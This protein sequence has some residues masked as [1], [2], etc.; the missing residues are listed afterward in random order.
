[1]KNL[2]K[3]YVFTNSRKIRDFN[4][5]FE[6]GLIPKTINIAEF[7]KK[8]IYVLNRFEADSTY[9]LVLM[10]QA[11]SRVKAAS[12]KLKIPTEFFAFL[13]NNNYLFS[14]FKELAIQKRSINDIKFRDIYADYE[15]HLS[16]LEEVLAAYK[17]LLANENLYDDIVLPEIYSL[18][19]T[20]ICSFDEIIV[21]IDG[22][23]SEFELE[24]F[25]KISHLTKLKFIFS[26]SKF[27]KKIINKIV[28]IFGLNADELEL[29]AKFE[30]D[31]SNKKFDKLH[32]LSTQTIVQTRSF[33]LRSLQ[34]AYVMAKIGEFVRDG[35]EAQNIVV[36]LPDESFS[37]ILRLYDN[38]RILNYAMGQSFIHTKFFQIL[39]LI[40]R[41]ISED[42]QI[43]FD[44]K[45]ATSYDEFGFKFN[46]FGISEEL[47]LQFKNSFDLPCKF[48]K[49]EKLIE[50]IIA[51]QS[52]RRALKIINKVMFDMKNLARY[53][54]FNLRQICEI[55]LMRLRSESIDD[56]G[57]GKV[58]VIGILESRGMKFDGVIVVDFNDDLIPKR[59][60]NEMFLSSRVR[61]K[62]GLISHN[63]RENLQRF[64]YESLIYGSKKSA[65]CYVQ[66][67]EKI[68][69][70][71]LK[72]FTCIVDDKYSDTSL[73]RL[74]G[75]GSVGL[76]MHEN[77]LIA[78]HDFFAYPLSFSRLNTFLNSPK[79]YYYKYILGIKE[80]KAIAQKTNVDYGNALH[81]V[82]FDYYSKYR[83]FKL[84]RFELILRNSDF[85]LLDIEILLLKFK[86]FEANEQIRYGKGWQVFECEKSFE[87]IKFEGIEI[88]GVIDRIDKNGDEVEII[89]YKSGNFDTKSL[90]LPFYQAL[91]GRECC[92]YFY[93]LK[94]KMCLYK[95]ES[96]LSEL[97][98]TIKELKKIN[99]TNINF[100]EVGRNFKASA[101]EILCKGEL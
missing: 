54:D 85:S 46:E 71:F 34:A 88:S 86:E 74:L 57:G 39:E 6:D 7:E 93:D 58:S 28:D 8:I 48:E 83:E 94:S 40:V 47:F 64:Y 50:Q 59:S 10:Q 89:D 43:C 38:K 66:N 22:F 81:K 12:E 52:D 14:F 84:D 95:S 51:F 68:G 70:R 1:M 30:F 33:A 99:N 36:V 60:I 73:A 5:N 42:L 55:F 90:Q 49:F 13:K 69:S 92:S 25:E 20:F 31:V 11:V 82:L 35:I 16:I 3:L 9:T 44:Q 26:T 21:E 80:P 19:E 29:N 67:E 97:K 75:I 61:Q 87:R 65:I 45:N 98:E 53:F 79:L 27:N 56:V 101:F 15:E 100:S 62:A 2:N 41:V 17:Q 78:K 77:E 72:E 18:N 24:L 37:E 4:T 32:K 91:L 96:S 63:D 23:L 76:K